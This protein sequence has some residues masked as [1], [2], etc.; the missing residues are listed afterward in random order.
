MSEEYRFFARCNKCETIL[1]KD[2]K[3]FPDVFR[4]CKICD[5][6]EEIKAAE[7]RGAERM[8][9]FLTIVKLKDLFEA[10]VEHE[11]FDKAKA[12]I[13]ADFETWEAKQHGR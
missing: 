5:K 3:P 4:L 10:D 11:D 6:S 2:T 7:K 1:L 9:D 8:F 12:L 13:L